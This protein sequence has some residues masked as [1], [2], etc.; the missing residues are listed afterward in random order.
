MCEWYG[1]KVPEDGR[2]PPLKV[3]SDD[4]DDAGLV[5]LWDGLWFA[6][7]EKQ[8]KVDEE[9]RDKFGRLFDFDVTPF[10]KLGGQVRGKGWREREADIVWRLGWMLLYE[11]VVLLIFFTKIAV[12]TIVHLV[13]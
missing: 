7:G 13:K 3:F 9:L 6:T 2:P 4:V 10:L 5:R 12:N 11:C 8:S 1:V